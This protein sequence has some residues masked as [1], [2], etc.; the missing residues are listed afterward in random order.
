MQR[1][2]SLLPFLAVLIGIGLFATMDGMM[3]AAA[4]ALGTYSALLWRYLIGSAAMIPAWLAMGGRWPSPEILR[5]HILR[6]MVTTL[7]G[8]TFFFA[9]T[10]LPLAEAIGISFF[11][12]LFA[13]Y[14]AWLMLGEQITRSAILASLLG[15]AGVAIIVLGRMD[16]ATNDARALEGIVAVVVSALLYAFNL[17]L[18]RKQALVADPREVACFQQATAA[19]ILLLAAPWFAV[20]PDSG[21]VWL[22]VVAAA[23]LGVGA[24]LFLTWGYKR[25]EAQVLLPLEYSAFVWAALVGWLLFRE[26]VTLATLGGTA[27]IVLGCWITLPRRKAVQAA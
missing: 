14:L 12:P 1:H 19:L 25:A 27:L 8:L 7:M 18:Q 15:L 17:I 2:S 5:L 22:F 11:A 10:R 16:S 23:L 26:D 24:L 9:L 6:G 3:K 4:L 20:F 13:L 21:S